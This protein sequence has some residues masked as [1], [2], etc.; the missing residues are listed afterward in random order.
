VKAAQVA[1]LGA[2]HPNT[3]T[4]LNNL[5]RAY[6]DAGQLPKALPLF[7]QAASGIEKRKFQ[8]QHAGGII[9]NT[10]RAYEAAQQYD[11]A[12]AWQ[13]R[14]LAV[15]KDKAG[16]LSPATARELAVLGG[17]LLNQEKWTD[18]EAPLKDC[19]ALRQKTQPQAWTTFNTMSMLGG[20][21]L[22]QKKYAA[23]EP[24]LLKG[25]Q[26]M[27][28]REKTIPPPFRKVRL[29]EAVERLMQLY[30][31]LEKK[32]AA[33]KWRKELEALNK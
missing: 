28:Q 6:Q 14:W 22:G 11:Q 23:A 3:L 2:N 26:G 15:V 27:K 31:A 21:L 18:A 8:H 5:A 1:K 12:E 20:A 7:E 16:P 17:L 33:A 19:L 25:Y 13:R 10:V 32:A 4:T 9:P 29:T 24:L 30:E